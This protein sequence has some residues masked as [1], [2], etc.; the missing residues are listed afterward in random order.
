MSADRHILSPTKENDFFISLYGVKIKHSDLLYLTWANFNFF[1]LILGS[2]FHSGRSLSQKKHKV[3]RSEFSR[4]TSLGGIR[5]CPVWFIFEALMGLA[6][7]RGWGGGGGEGSAKAIGCSG[8][9]AWPHVAQ[10]GSTLLQVSL[11]AQY[12]GCQIIS[13]TNM[14]TNVTWP[15]M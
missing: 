7:Q 8:L 10:T 1:Y 9:W 11:G 14:S 13:A 2:Q 6:D 15:L 4:L 3:Q 5:T 12:S